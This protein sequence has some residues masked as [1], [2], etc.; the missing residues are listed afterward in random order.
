MITY[1][2][3]SRYDEYHRGGLHCGVLD[4]IGLH[5]R[6]N[7]L[8][9]QITKYPYL[10]PV[11][12]YISS[13]DPQGRIVLLAKSSLRDSKGIVLAIPNGSKIERKE[14]PCL[15]L[16]LAYNILTVSISAEACFRRAELPNPSITERH[17]LYHLMKLCQRFEPR[18]P[19]LRFTSH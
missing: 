9:D 8:W 5:S 3:P 12:A 15:S 10:S 11:A 4:W 1:T 19:P 7:L 13:G 14:Q 18:S 2:S 6:R 17:G 16:V